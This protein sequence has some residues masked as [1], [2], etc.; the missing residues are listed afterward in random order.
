MFSSMGVFGVVV[1]LT[2]EKKKMEAI[3]NYEHYNTEMEKALAD[4]LFFVDNI[5]DCKT[6]I[7][8]GC[9]D[10]ALLVA[11]NDMLPGV[12]LAG[13]DMDKEMLEKASAKDE[14]TFIGIFLLSTLVPWITKFISADV[15]GFCFW[16]PYF[17]MLYYCSGYL[18]YLVMAHYIRAD[19][20]DLGLFGQL[21][22]KV[23]SVFGGRGMGL[24]YM[25]VVGIL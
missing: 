20:D 12:K 21:H 13:M 6:F 16:N 24:E 11:M 2:G 9:A 19:V 3:K 8:F 23:S 18:G 22:I 1:H 5:K 10:G 17:G 4:K 15:W 14:R 25:E 7:D